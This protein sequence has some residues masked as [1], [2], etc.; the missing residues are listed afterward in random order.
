[1]KKLLLLGASG[2]IGKQTLEVCETHPYDLQI[3]GV[4]VGNNT[5]ALYQILNKHREIKYAYSIEEKPELELL[6][7]NVKFFFGE[8]GLVE[9]VK[10]Q[11]YDLLVNALVG[12]VGL[13]PTIEGIKNYKDIAL[14]N[15]ESL[16]AAGDIV[17]A[18]LKEYKVNLYPIDSEHS[19]IW[20]CLQG[21]DS[22]DIK[23][24][25]ITGSGGSFRKLNRSQL[26]NVTVEEALN[27]PT[28]DM[29]A[30][31]TVDCATM[32]NKGFEV[33]EAHYLF[34]IDYEN[35]DVI[36]HD[37]SIVHSFVE[38]KDGSTLAQM[39]TPD[40]RIPIQ[41]ALLYPSHCLSPHEEK[42]DLG[43]ISELHFK[44]M[45]YERYPLVKIVKD[46]GKFGGNI[47]AII[48]GANDTAV[49]LFIEGKISFL[50]IEEAIKL[51]LRNIPYKKNVTIDDIFEAHDKARDLVLSH[52][53]SE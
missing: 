4:S 5:D 36:L 39:S 14:A 26:V 45:D 15:K 47:G 8:D 3:V 40:M 21:S 6:F 10:Q 34:D 7:P 35:I 43:R 48:N 23:R 20:Q 18:L 1:M 30:K 53:V 16:V 37:E 52:Y 38:Y 12:F 19:A 41:Y 42:L 46:I 11:D 49:S 51:A 24:L 44:E 31:I 50:D 25:I 32:M 17:K 13:K 27:H 33:M 28:W 2:S 9:I 29:G 22:K